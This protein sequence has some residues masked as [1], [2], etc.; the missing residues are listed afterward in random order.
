MVAGIWYLRNYFLTG[1]ML[2]D[3]FFNITDYHWAQDF[4]ISTMASLP[5][6]S[7]FSFLFY[8]VVIPFTSYALGTLWVIP[9]V[10][11]FI[12]ASKESKWPFFVLVW[13]LGFLIGYFWSNFYEFQTTTADPRE[14]YPLA[15]FL[16]IFIAIGIVYISG[17]LSKNNR[18]MV[19]AILLLSFGL[20]SLSQSSLIYQYGPASFRS[21]FVI[22][23]NSLGSSLGALAGK[24]PN[25]PE[26]LASAA[27]RLLL[28]SLAVSLIILGPLFVPKL[29]AC[30]LKHVQRVRRERRCHLVHLR[31]PYQ[32]IALLILLFALMLLPYLAMSFEFGNGNIND[33]GKNQLDPLY[34]GLYTNVA[35]YVENNTQNGDVILMLNSYGFQYYLHRDVTVLDLSTPGDLAVFRDAVES[36][37]VSLVLSILDAQNIRY[38]LLP[39]GNSPL[40]TKL[41]EESILIDIINDPAYFAQAK[42]FG[43]WVLYEFIYGRLQ[44]TQGWV[45]TS[46]LTNWTVV[47]GNF[48]NLIGNST[49]LSITVSANTTVIL[50]YSGIPTIDTTAYPFLACNLTGS[51]NARY[52]FRLFSI[53]EKISY[54]FPYWA[55]PLENGGIRT[56]NLAES[57]LVNTRL[58][59]EAFLDVQ[60]VNQYP[61]TL[62]VSF[63]MIF[64][65]DQ[66][67]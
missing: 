53:D 2:W 29:S 44:I 36:S 63:F 40:M 42:N 62:D 18:N 66:T 16:S 41:S 47:S 48:T 59:Y 17:Y 27:P 9:K 55:I 10:V 26:L 5:T 61:A 14:L 39:K 8:I 65:Y 33:F 23:A 49:T 38:V 4:I 25:Y 30:A 20:L 22:A 6:T 1:S 24:I 37:N 60:S 15:P 54:D 35:S 56:Y 12:K 34:W 19:T 51:N 13:V 32:K 52:L 28:F 45:E 58:S 31:N 57:P 11:G 50:R 64:R 3:N 67:K 46:F 21:F 43:S 7:A